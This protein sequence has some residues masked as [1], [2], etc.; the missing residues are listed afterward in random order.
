VILDVRG[1]RGGA[2][3]VLVA[4]LSYF[5]EGEVGAFYTRGSEPCSR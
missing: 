2:P 4:L 5:L 1:T 3:G